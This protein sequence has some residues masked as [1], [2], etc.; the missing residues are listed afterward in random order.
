M[1]LWL[2]LLMMLAGPGRGFAAASSTTRAAP[3]ES[4][5]LA[6]STCRLPLRIVGLLDLLLKKLLLD[7]DLLPMG[8]DLLL[9]LK[10]RDPP[11]PLLLP[12]SSWPRADYCRLRGRP[13]PSFLF[14]YCGYARRRPPA[15][16]IVGHPGVITRTRYPHTCSHRSRRGPPID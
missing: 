1:A 2:V 14:Y 12:S 8:L 10:L 7:L 5:T 15:F 6:S 4:T 13:G 16:R 3:T 9:L 11:L